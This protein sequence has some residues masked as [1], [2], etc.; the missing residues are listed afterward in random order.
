MRPALWLCGALSCAP[1]E[2]VPAARPASVRFRPG[3]P[4]DEAGRWLVESVPRAQWDL[5]L[6]RAA[7]TLLS[8]AQDRRAALDPAATQAVLA[9]EGYP[10]PA[11]FSRVLTGGALPDGLIDEIVGSA[12]DDLP[13]DVGL[14][15]R[16]YGDGLTLW[17]AGWAPRYADLDPMPRDLPLDGTL[18]VRVELP[19]QADA[20]LYLV[21]PDGPVEE[22]SLTSK[23]S[24]WVDHF[25]R[26]GAYRMSVGYQDGEVT[27]VALVWSVFVGVDPPLPSPLRPLPP[28]PDPVAAEATLYDA[29]NTLRATHGLP[30]V[31]RFSTFEPLCREHAALMA[32][33]GQVAHAL[34][35]VTEGVAERAKGQFHPRAEHHEDVAAAASAADVLALVEGSPAHLSNLLCAACTHVSIGAALEPALDRPPRLFVTWELLRF[36]NGPPQPVDHYNR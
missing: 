10:G 26:P 24:R 19:P 7:S 9:R 29:L 15:G 17:V 8:L 20:R 2:S 21:P 31:Q 30:P 11:R 16:T 5:G 32:A 18:A 1:K 22:L 28:T 3:D 34:P 35:G 6:A 25:E 14:A 36:P 27:R 12:P 4:S 23:V 13:I 33:H